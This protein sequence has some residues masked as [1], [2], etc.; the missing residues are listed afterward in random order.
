MNESNLLY[1]NN[2]VNIYLN[3]KYIYWKSHATKC[4]DKDL[5]ELIAVS[6]TILDKLFIEKKMIGMIWDMTSTQILSPK[7]INNITK[8]I[9]G[10]TDK[11]DSITI[12]SLI[13]INNS[14]VRNLISIGLKICPP[15]K[16][17]VIITDTYDKAIE[18]IEYHRNLLTESG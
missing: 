6:N 8:F 15:K 14:F 5:D 3:S 16:R 17:P 9:T 10:R 12:A 2:Y 13:I 11:N 4:A 7:Q 18:I 1:S